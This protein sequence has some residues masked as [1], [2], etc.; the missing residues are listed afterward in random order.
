M[1]LPYLHSEKSE[2]ND[3]EEEKKKK[4]HNG[5]KRIEKR[6]NKITKRGPIS[7][8]REIFEWNI[9]LQFSDLIKIR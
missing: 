9:P 8:R 5:T 2:D 6:C 3:E 1:V 7:E 4:R